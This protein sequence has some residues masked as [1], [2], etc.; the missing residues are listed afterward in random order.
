MFDVIFAISSLYNILYY[1]SESRSMLGAVSLSSIVAA[2]LHLICFMWS[3]LTVCCA[4]VLCASS[5]AM[6]STLAPTHAHTRL[7]DLSMHLHP[8]LLHPSLTPPHLQ[9]TYLQD[10]G[11]SISHSPVSISVDDLNVVVIDD[12]SR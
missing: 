9:N 4:G 11:H 1:S 6:P 5:G 8:I 12:D 7:F 3:M 10:G 2:H